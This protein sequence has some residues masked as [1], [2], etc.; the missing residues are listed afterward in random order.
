LNVIY[1]D[2]NFRRRSKTIINGYKN[3][4]YLII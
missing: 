2:K 3:E 4:I 1:C